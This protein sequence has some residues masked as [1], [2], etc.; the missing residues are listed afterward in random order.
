M[1]GF[2]THLMTMQPIVLIASPL[3]RLRVPTL[4]SLQRAS[5]IGRTLLVK[6]QVLSQ[7]IA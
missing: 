4:A 2:A 1:N 7:G 5:L 3:I 6:R